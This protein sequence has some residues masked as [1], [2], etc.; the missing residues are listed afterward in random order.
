MKTL[1]LNGSP[2][3]E[4]GNTQIFLNEITSQIV[5]ETFEIKSIVKQNQADIVSYMEEFDTII[6]AMPLYIHAMPGIVKR[7][8]EEMKVNEV[9][10]RKLGF[11][12]QAGFE[13]SETAKYLEQ[14]L[15]VF[16]KRM[17]YIYLGMV[18]KPGAAGVGMMPLFLSRKLFKQLRML[19]AH[20]NQT[21]EFS[22]E[23]MKKLQHPY[24]LSNR[25]VKIYS[26]KIV[27][28]LNKVMWHKNLKKNG[29]YSQRIDRPFYSHF[30]IV[31]LENSAV[32]Y[33]VTA[34]SKKRIK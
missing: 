6:I 24:K 22:D 11:I 3:G 13:E 12:V 34:I 32:N 15:N 26:S 27:G 33:N 4:M 30:S 25:Q 7:I 31:V 9:S 19:G 8:F 10:G 16:C 2:K 23:I 5:N 29:A 28:N 18:I 17:N 1:F 21:G 14:Y 20:Y